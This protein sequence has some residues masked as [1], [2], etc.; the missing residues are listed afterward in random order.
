MN[1]K[2]K[3]TN[4]DGVVR[5]ESSGEIKEVLFKEDFLKPNQAGIAI[6]FK[7]K[8]SSGILELTPK[9]MESII[10]DFTGKKDLFK[11]PKVMKFEKE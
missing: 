11:T 2:T 5:L 6:C 10:H 8:D 1:I 3:K 4:K 9:E 7:G